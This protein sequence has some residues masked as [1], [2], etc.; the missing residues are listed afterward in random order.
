M[1]QETI[2]IIAI[3]ALIVGVLIGFLIAKSGSGDAERK[4]LEEELNGSRAEMDRY[5]EE[6]TT[7]FEHT[8][9]LVNDLTDQYRKVHQH[10]ATGAQN[11]CPDQK[12]GKSLQSS[13][14]PKLES[15]SKT[16]VETPVETAGIDETGIDETGIDEKATA[17]VSEDVSVK[18]TESVEMKAAQEPAIEPDH[19]IEA[20]K[21]WAPK[22][23]NDEGTLSDSY[24]L[25]KKDADALN[26]PQP[27][28]GLN[29]DEPEKKVQG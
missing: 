9:A 26:P 16:P 23:P 11:L 4:V 6:V 7:H 20:P 5:K 18:D 14:Q 3:V 25:K 24:G 15:T 27:D 13:L 19:N 8:A 1:E 2:W 28:P 10:L 22:K 12:P 29:E 21:D 17:E